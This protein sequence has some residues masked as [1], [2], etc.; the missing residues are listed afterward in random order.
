MVLPS[1]LTGPHCPTIKTHSITINQ[2]KHWKLGEEDKRLGKPAKVSVTYAKQDHLSTLLQMPKDHNEEQP[3]HLCRGR[4]MTGRVGWRGV[5]FKSAEN[6]YQS[7]FRP[8][9][10]HFLEIKIQEG[11]EILSALKQNKQGIVCINFWGSDRSM[12]LV[13]GVPGTAHLY[14][15]PQGFHVGDLKTYQFWWT[16]D[17]ALQIH[18]RLSFLLD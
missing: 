12:L 7:L 8:M 3:G 13:P 14:S 6:L 4:V 9:G 5:F 18:S 11:F 1:D 10:D 16:W 17:T 2:S 15:S